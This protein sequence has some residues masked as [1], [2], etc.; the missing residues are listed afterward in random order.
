M[1]TFDNLMRNILIIWEN[2]M[3]FRIFKR[4]DENWRENRKTGY[5]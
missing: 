1:E 5:L 4:N 3:K 2:S